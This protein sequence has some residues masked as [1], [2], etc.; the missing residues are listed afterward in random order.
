VVS[1]DRRNTCKA[2]YAGKYRGQRDERYRKRIRRV[3]QL[4]NWRIAAIL[5]V[6]VGYYSHEY[7]KGTTK[8]CVYDS[9]YGSH[10]MTIGATQVCPM[11]M[12][13]EI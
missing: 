1:T 2:C 5:M 9:T 10:A 7:I 4:I 13:F 6:V 12:E 3:N 8:T 11:T